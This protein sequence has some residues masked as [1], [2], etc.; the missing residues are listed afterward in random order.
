MSTANP[1]RTRTGV[2]CRT[3]ESQRPCGHP[4]CE[5][6][7]YSRARLSAEV[8]ATALD[9]PVSAQESTAVQKPSDASV[10]LTREELWSLQRAVF[11]R[12]MQYPRETGLRTAGDKIN[13]ALGL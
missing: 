12:L 2:Q 9:A 1:N 11:G 5:R 6:P 8:F 7:E 10:S 4:S 13:R 3:M